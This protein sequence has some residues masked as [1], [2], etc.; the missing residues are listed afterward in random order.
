MLKNKWGVTIR[1]ETQ[2]NLLKPKGKKLLLLSYPGKLH[3]SIK[4]RNSNNNPEF[5]SSQK[6]YSFIDEQVVTIFHLL[7]KGNNLKLPKVRRPTKLDVQTI[8]T[9]IS[10]TGWF[11]ILQVNASSSRIRFKYWL[12]LVFCH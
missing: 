12:T 9:I 8:P 2:P 6:Q 3:R 1:G 10:S 4:M 5:K 11:T 7:N